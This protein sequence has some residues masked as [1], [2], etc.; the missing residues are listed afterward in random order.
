LVEEKC[1]G[2]IRVRFVGVARGKGVNRTRVVV[3]LLSFIV[4][5]IIRIVVNI[6]FWPGLTRSNGRG[7]FCKCGQ[8]KVLILSTSACWDSIGSLTEDLG[9]GSFP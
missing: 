1:T 5:V 8:P 3:V 6:Y 4:V 2:N 7:G 9:L